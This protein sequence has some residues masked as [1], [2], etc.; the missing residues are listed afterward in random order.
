VPGFSDIIGPY[1]RSITSLEIQPSLTLQ[2]TTTTCLHVGLQ[3]QISPTALRTS[4]GVNS[5]AFTPHSKQVCAVTKCPWSLSPRMARRIHYLHAAYLHHSL[6]CSGCVRYHLH[7]AERSRRLLLLC[8]HLAS[9]AMP[10][11][12]VLCAHQ[13]AHKQCT[14]V[15]SAS[16]R[17]RQRHTCCECNE[18]RMHAVCGGLLSIM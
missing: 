6:C 1:L 2:T 13:P 18:A 3:L 7:N 5:S 14:Q 8:I 12:P 16:G 9:C 11:W 15:L 17:Q 4:R 10:D